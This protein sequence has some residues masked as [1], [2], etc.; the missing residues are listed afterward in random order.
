MLEAF[1]ASI[2]AVIVIVTAPT[3]PIPLITVAIGA[4][5]LG[6]TVCTGVAIVRI[7]VY[8]IWTTVAII[9]IAV[10]AIAIGWVSVSPIAVGRPP[11]P[12]AEMPIVMVAIPG[13]RGR[14]DQRDSSRREKQ[15]FEHI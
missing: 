13:T 9:R 1:R 8:V 15:F 5:S 4:I 10:G 14:R 2:F 6:I 12:V 7:T 3:L 11:I